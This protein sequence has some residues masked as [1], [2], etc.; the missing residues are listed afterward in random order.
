VV[1]WRDEQTLFRVLMF[2]WAPE[3]L[4][5]WNSAS[6]FRHLVG[7]SLCCP[8]YSARQITPNTRLWPD[9]W[10]YGT[11]QVIWNSLNGSFQM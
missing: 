4:F 6:F 11:F 2:N 7:F 10:I 9:Y 5:T 3:A 8:S 1:P